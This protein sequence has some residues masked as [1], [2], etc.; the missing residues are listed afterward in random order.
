MNLLE[1]RGYTMAGPD[2]L[3]QIFRVRSCGRG[4]LCT[5][6]GD[7]GGRSLQHHSTDED[8]NSQIPGDKNQILCFVREDQYNRYSA[9][10]DD[11]PVYV[12]STLSAR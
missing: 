4:W 10:S 5:D 9:A 1:T 2:W 7:I 3:L 11:Q 8:L 6:I 12:N